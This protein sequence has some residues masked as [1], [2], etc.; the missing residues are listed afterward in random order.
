MNVSYLTN[1]EL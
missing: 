1:K